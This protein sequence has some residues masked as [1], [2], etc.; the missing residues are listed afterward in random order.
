MREPDV[1]E[2]RDNFLRE[3]TSHSM[4]AHGNPGKI[5]PTC[6]EC[7]RIATNMIHNL[8]LTVEQVVAKAKSDDTAERYRGVASIVAEMYGATPASVW[9]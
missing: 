2:L 8:G 5:V 9:D 7:K 4:A 3:A 6:A 1:S